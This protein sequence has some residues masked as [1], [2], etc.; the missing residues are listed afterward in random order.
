MKRAEPKVAKMKI[1]QRDDRMESRKSFMKAEFG[2]QARRLCVRNSLKIQ[3]G[4]GDLMLN[5][6]T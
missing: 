3:F 6:W 4:S 5:A 1:K 2:M